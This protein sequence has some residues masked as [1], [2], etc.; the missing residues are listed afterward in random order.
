M[1]IKILIMKIR[2]EKQAQCVSGGGVEGR[3]RVKEGD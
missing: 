3:E 2:T 1:S